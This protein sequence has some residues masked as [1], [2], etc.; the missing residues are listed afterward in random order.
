MEGEAF[1]KCAWLPPTRVSPEQKRRIDKHCERLDISLGARI[2]EL[3][4]LDILAHSHFDIQI[5]VG[6][7]RRPRRAA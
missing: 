4:R 6:P 2:L 7:V 5:E 1:K 3:I